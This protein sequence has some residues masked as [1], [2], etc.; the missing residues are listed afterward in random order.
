MLF[1]ALLA[2]LLWPSEGSDRPFVAARTVGEKAAKRSGSA[3]GCCWP[4][5]RWSAR[6]AHRRRST[7]CVAVLHHGQ[8]GWL[9]HIDRSTESLFLHHGTT[10][11]I[12]LAVVC[13]VVAAGVLMPPKVTQIT[14]VLAVV[15]FAL[16]WVAVQTSVAFWPA[17]LRPQRR[18]GD[19]D[20]VALLATRRGRPRRR[21]ASGGLTGMVMSTP[22]WLYYLFGAL[23]LVVAAYCSTL[24]ILGV[25]TDRPAGRD[26]EISH[27]F[28]GVAMAGM[29]VGGWSFGPSAIWEIIFSLLMIWFLV[30]SVQSVQRYGLHLPHASIHALMNFTML[31]MY[32][33]P[34]G[35]STFRID[36][37]VRGVV[38]RQARSGAGPR[39]GPH[40][41]RL[42]RVHPGLAGQGSDPFRQS[43]PGVR[44]ERV[45]RVFVGRQTLRRRRSHRP[46]PSTRRWPRRGWWTSATW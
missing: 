21:P 17:G 45:G 42:G 40:P 5:C 20:R 26:V 25:V 9:A 8:P 14:V 36:V 41:L 34:V 19:P 39:P 16:I 2:V 33:F 30:A 43:R 6:A 35:A 12:L 18:A 29:F 28:M 23:M 3:C 10:M 46:W 24:L 7:T 15:V 31:L 38:G 27:L 37:H 1:Y 32:W 4:S 22:S 11:A 44:H 13:L